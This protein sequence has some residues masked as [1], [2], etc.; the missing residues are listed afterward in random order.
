VSVD[1]AVGDPVAAALAEVLPPFATVD[2]VARAGQVHA[3]TVR[4]AIA[5]GE[6]E[7]TRWGSQWRVPRGAVQAWI[8]GR[9]R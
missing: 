9:C 1:L 6:L 8:I 2:E 7:A 5:C 3:N 4:R